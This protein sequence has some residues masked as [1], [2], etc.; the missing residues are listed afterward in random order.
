MRKKTFLYFRGQKPIALCHGCSVAAQVFCFRKPPRILRGVASFLAISL[1]L[2]ACVYSFASELTVDSRITEVTVYPDSALIT[3]VANVKVSA[4]EHKLIFSE[5]I[6]EV[7]ENTLRV[8]AEGNCEFK[9]FGAQLKREYLEETPV[10][11]VK[12]LQ[13]QIKKYEDEI[14]KIQ[15]LKNVYLEEKNFLDSIRMFSRDQI[16]KDLVTKMPQTTDLENVYKFLDARLKEHYS[17][18]MENDLKIRELHEKTDVLRRKFSEISGPLK[19]LKRSILVDV[20]AVKAGNIDIVLSY[21]VRGA[22]WQPIYDARASF[23][24]SQVELVSYGIIRQV[25][26]EDW[27]DVDISLSTAKP[28]IGGNLPYVAPWILRLFQPRVFGDEKAKFAENK[29]AFR[30]ASQTEAYNLEALNQPFEEADKKDLDSLAKREIFAKVEE[31]GVAVVYKLPRK[32]LVKSDGSEHK[33]PVSSQILQAKFKYSTYPRLSNYAYLGSRVSNAKE[34]QLLAGR[35]NI[36]LEGDFVGASSITNI[37]P[38][39][40]FDLYLGVDENV[41]VKREKVS[42]KVDDVLIAGIPSPNRKTTLKYKTTL[43][44]YKNKKIEVLFFEAMPVPEDE[45]IKVKTSDV[46]LPPVEKDWKDRKG[47]WRWELEL[48]PKEKK[49]IFYTFSIEHPRDMQVEGL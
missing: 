25:T 48:S 11:K 22:S 31:K 47:I 35:V 10:E 18:V 34:L 1:I 15:D 14:R 12:E 5:I 4:G 43:E 32:A 38:G 16:P 40:E 39:E 33:L 20:E 41:K 49:E 26:G 2:S 17:L 46:S 44:N 21:L 29:R 3:R 23:D 9:L 37:G 28:A 19:K 13:E 36:F 24:N 30:I 8:S 45:R 7:D 27:L 6:P 42:K